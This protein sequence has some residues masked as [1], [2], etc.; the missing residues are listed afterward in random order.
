MG[1]A[2]LHRDTDIGP[3]KIHAAIRH[4]AALA[5]HVVQSLA[6]QNDDVSALTAAQA[7]EQR[8]GRRKI[9]IDAHTA[10]GLIPSGQIVNCPL[11]GQRREYSHG[12]VHC[13]MPGA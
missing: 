3:C 12:I 9:S 13:V 8:Q 1:G 11:Q 7:I 2:R 10:G 5:D 6:G 4:D